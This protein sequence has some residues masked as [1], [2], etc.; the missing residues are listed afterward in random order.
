MKSSR[1]LLDNL[2]LQKT[3]RSGAHTFAAGHPMPFEPHHNGDPEIQIKTAVKSLPKSLLSE[4]DSRRWVA[5]TFRD[6]G[7]GLLPEV[8][9]SLAEM[10]NRPNELLK[11]GSLALSHRIVVAKHGGRFKVKSQRFKNPLNR[12]KLGT[13]V[14][15]LIP[16][17][18]QQ[19]A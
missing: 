2:L 18:T 5:I 8:E 17:T 6:N 3:H 12:V 7:P 9:K 13:E 19:D 15:I 16:L 11:T 10:A 14:E 4:N 1:E